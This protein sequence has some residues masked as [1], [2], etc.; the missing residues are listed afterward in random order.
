MKKKSY[1]VP[2]AIL[3]FIISRLLYLFFLNDRDVMTDFKLIEVRYPGLV[4]KHL[5]D[6]LIMPFWDYQY[7]SYDGGTLITS[8]MLAPFFGLLGPSSLTLAFYGL[9]NSLVTFL[10]WWRLT[11]RYFGEKTGWILVLLFILAPP[12]HIKVTLL[13][14]GNH[15]EVSLFIILIIHFFFKIFY[16]P[17]TDA[18][19][20]KNRFPV[21]ADFMFLGLFAG[22]GVYFCYSTAVL[23]LS[24]FLFW[25]TL[26]KRGHVIRNYVGMALTFVA[27]I[28]FIFPRLAMFDA[29]IQNEILTQWPVVNLNEFL[30]RIVGVMFSQ[31]PQTISSSSPVHRPVYFLFIGTVLFCVLLDRRAWIRQSFALLPGKDRK[32]AFDQTNGVHF[33]ILFTLLYLVIDAVS[34]FNTYL[35]PESPIRHRY[36]YLLF[37][38]ILMITAVGISRLASKGKPGKSLAAAFLIYWIFAGSVSTWQQLDFRNP[39]KKISRRLRSPGY[40]PEMLGTVLCTRYALDP[41]KSLALINRVNEE[42]I[43]AVFRGFG[44]EFGIIQHLHMEDYRTR[45]TNRRHKEELYKGLSLG[46]ITEKYFKN[47]DADSAYL[48]EMLAA[49]ACRDQEHL[50]RGLLNYADTSA[51]ADKTLPYQGAGTILAIQ[52]GLRDKTEFNFLEGRNHADIRAFEEGIHNGLKFNKNILPN[53]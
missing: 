26:D 17:D 23:L 43:P 5:L 21:L 45:I 36:F 46:I 3:L 13:P 50:G 25:L 52:C 37:P 2:A 47:T 40:A 38:F 30:P 39:C 18:P 32:V 9:I 12:L 33:F 28:S 41:E 6:G 44:Y 31:L 15:I 11:N 34:N 53:L 1:L 22:L 42:E 27:G 24:C 16:A 14:S 10:L 7:S 8:L 19:Q 4:A 35:D 48:Y 20:K 51:L 29:S 49:D